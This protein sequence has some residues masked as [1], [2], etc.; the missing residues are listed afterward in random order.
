MADVSQNVH[1]LEDVTLWQVDLEDVAKQI[2]LPMHVLLDSLS[3]H[4][5]PQVDRDGGTSGTYASY[6]VC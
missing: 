1:A 2:D 3:I 4:A 6:S 5:A